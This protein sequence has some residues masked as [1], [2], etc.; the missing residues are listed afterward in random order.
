MQ[1][2]SRD[3]S[4][5][6]QSV[7]PVQWR[8]T[9][10]N[11][12]KM[13]YLYL[14]MVICMMDFFRFFVC[15]AA[16]GIDNVI[17][18]VYTERES[19]WLILQHA[20]VFQLCYCVIVLL[21]QITNRTSIFHLALLYGTFFV[22][23]TSMDFPIIVLKVRHLSQSI[24]VENTCEE[25]QHTHTHYTP[26]SERRK[27]HIRRECLRKWRYGWAQQSASFAPLDSALQCEHKMSKRSP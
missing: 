16:A 23:C 4:H 7:H 5:D 17:P 9:Y 3:R 13:W 2:G 11:G 25:Q 6:H 22:F 10:P 18:W 19:D 1:G 15:R 14:F 21:C 12:T 8:L 20:R 26:L 24:S 27:E